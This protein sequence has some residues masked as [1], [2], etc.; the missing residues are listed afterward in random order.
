[1]VGTRATEPARRS[2]ISSRSSA[3]IVRATR[4]CCVIPPPLDW[5]GVTVLQWRQV[6]QVNHDQ[7]DNYV[8]A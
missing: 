1:M 8:L 5:L 7:I 2:R 3:E 4:G 6:D